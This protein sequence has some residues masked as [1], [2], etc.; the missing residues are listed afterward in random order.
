MQV[1]MLLNV[2]RTTPK[3]ITLYCIKYKCTMYIKLLNP[4]NKLFQLG[5][6]A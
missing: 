1:A 4:L 5:N 6:I 3:M 2:D